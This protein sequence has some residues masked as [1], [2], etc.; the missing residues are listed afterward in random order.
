MSSNSVR[1][2]AEL[3][4]AAKSEGALMSRSAADQVE[5]WAR[6]GAALESCNLTVGEVA[7]LLRGTPS[8]AADGGAL[9]AFKRARQAADMTAAS[10]GRVTQDD[11]S[12]FAGGRAKQTKV[13]GSPY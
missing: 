2:N 6:L 7:S 5:H 11:L 9:W 4:N 12:W 10:E 1:I 13:H 8:R 3:F